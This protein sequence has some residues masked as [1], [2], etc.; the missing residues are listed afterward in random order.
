MSVN[1]D[2]F[3]RIYRAYYRA[4]L[5]VVR[6]K[7]SCP[8]IAEDVLQDAFIKIWIALP[9]YNLDK[10]GIYTWMA[11]ICTHEAIDHLKSRSYRKNTMTD[12]LEPELKNLDG[13]QVCV[14]REDE[15]DVLFQVS[16][17][18]KTYAEPIQLYSTGYT[19]TEIGNMLDIP[20]G[21]VKTR[22]RTGLLILK[23][24]W[25]YDAA[26]CNCITLC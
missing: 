6:Y 17:L 8:E 14:I 19:H 3:D 20:L 9:N 22:I 4:L 16:L 26:V 5:K 15:M 2:S 12:Q 18:R 25:A 1:Q 13:R 11:T 23:K 24:V 7:I 10:G 21:T